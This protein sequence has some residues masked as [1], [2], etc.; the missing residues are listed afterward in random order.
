MMTVSSGVVQLPIFDTEDLMGRIGHD[1][2]LACELMAMYLQD[3]PQ[4]LDDLSQAVDSKNFE[5]I[6]ITAHSI[7]GASANMGAPQ[8]KEWAFC[9][10]M[11]GKAGEAKDLEL[12]FFELN[13]SY[14]MF[15]AYCQC[16][17]QKSPPLSPLSLEELKGASK[18][19]FSSP[20][21]SSW[22]ENTK[23]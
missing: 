14:S 15:S 16:S 2:E 5:K 6:A 18:F 17:S 13:R 12:L 9:L 1:E 11:A 4:L 22:S 23:G 8:V 10:E 19:I 3:M 20:D 7:K 21:V